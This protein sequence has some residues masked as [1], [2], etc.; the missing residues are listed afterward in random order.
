MQLKAYLYPKWDRKVA[1][2]ER[3]FEDTRFGTRTD[4]LPSRTDM[5]REGGL[6]HGHT[7]D[8]EAFW[9]ALQESDIFWAPLQSLNV[10]RKVRQTEIDKRI[11]DRRELNPNSTQLMGETGPKLSDVQ[12]GL[13]HT[14]WIFAPI[15][16]LLGQ[17]KD[18]NFASNQKFVT[19][20]VFGDKKG[21]KV[22][23][24]GLFIRGRWEV[25]RLDEKKI[26]ST[27][28]PII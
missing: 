21:K 8:N 9:S 7:V 11:G 12:Q 1:S 19:S 24:I 5:K 18:P 2:I 17:E 20:L 27:K 26:I 25:V 23:G 4:V 14:D 16:A 22:I 6:I 3:F 13:M 15:M 10:N 28:T